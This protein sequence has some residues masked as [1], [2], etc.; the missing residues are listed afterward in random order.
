[1]TGWW[2]TSK[3]KTLPDQTCFRVLVEI[4]LIWRVLFY[5][6]QDPCFDVRTTACSG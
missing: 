1:V 2:M 3:I 5:F 6:D 4:D